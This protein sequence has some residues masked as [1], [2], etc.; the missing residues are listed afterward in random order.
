MNE[1]DFEVATTVSTPTQKEATRTLRD[2]GTRFLDFLS[3]V[4]KLQGNKPQRQ[5]K[6]SE[7][8]ILSSQLPSIPKLIKV[9]PSRNKNVWLTVHQPAKPKPAVLPHQISDFV[10]PRSIRRTTSSPKLGGTDYILLE[11]TALNADGSISRP[12]QRNAHQKLQEIKDIF[13]N[14]KVTEW[15]DWVAANK[16]LENAYDL[17]QQLFNLYL[18][19]DQDSDYFELLFGHAILTWNGRNKVAYPLILTTA[20]IIFKQETGTIQV[21]EV[22]QSRMSVAPYADTDLLGYPLLNDLQESF[23]KEPISPWD[24]AEFPVFEKKLLLQ[25]GANSKRNLGLNLDP[26]EDPTLQTGWTL[27]M[28]KRTD[29]RSLFYKN[30]AKKLRSSDYLPEAFDSIFSDTK[31]ID[32]ALGKNGEKA[33]DGT[34]DRI[35]MPLPS[36][37]EQQRIAYRLAQNAGITVQGPQGPENPTPSST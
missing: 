15:P 29:N 11:N 19:Q 9:G 36:N 5:L 21:E 33:S 17:Y 20:H 35:L 2:K 8:F 28:R 25:L 26:T 22:G 1:P 18:R 32:A 16:D 13:N 7:S 12:K 31:T 6:S 10:D 34:A 30:L 14:W 4:A 37:Q 3:A 23:N 27:F 24:L